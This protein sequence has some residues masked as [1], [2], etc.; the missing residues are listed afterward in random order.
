MGNVA[1]I[2]GAVSLIRDRELDTRGTPTGS[3]EVLATAT[4]MAQQGTGF[5]VDAH[6]VADR[7]TAEG[8]VKSGHLAAVEGVDGG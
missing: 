5:I 2:A 6:R 3:K 4:L 7:M 1:S 8:L